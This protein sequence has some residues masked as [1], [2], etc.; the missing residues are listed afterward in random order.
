[1][2]RGILLSTAVFV[3]LSPI[4]C[5]GETRYVRAGDDLQAALNAARPGD[6]LRL[7]PDTTFS[8]N[9]VLP[10]TAGTS[11]ITVRTDLPDE[12]LPGPRQR[13]SPV[14]AARF[15]R[16]ASPN[17]AAALRTAPGANRW[18]LMFLTFPST[19]NG[20]GD[21]I[22][23]G[24]GSSAQSELSQVPYDIVLDRLYIHGDRTQGQ[25][26]GVALNARAVTIRN[27]HI[28]DI[29]AVGV[30]AQAIG[31][32]NGP[33]PFTIE[34][35]YLEA[36]G[37]VFLLGGSDPPIVNLVPADVSVRYN[38][39]TRPMAWRDAIV[40]PPVGVTA[41]GG[42]PGSLATGIYA[43]RVVA[44]SASGAGTVATS[45]P[46]SEVTAVASGGGVTVSWQ[47]VADASEYRVYVRTPAGATEY[48]TVTAPSFIHDGAPGR[49]GTPPTAATVWQVKNI[50]ELKAGRR[51]RVEYN[52]LENN[53]KNAQPGYAV[54]FTPRN[55]GGKCTW[56]VIEQVEFN[57]NVVRNVGGAFN[58][59]GYDV[60]AVTAQTNAIT[61][62]NNFV[63]DVTTELGGTGWPFLVGEAVRDVTIDHNTFDFD[64]S[65]LVYA[66][67]GTKT[68]PKP[69]T[70]FRFTNNAAPHGQYGINGANASTGTL[71]LQ[72]YFPAAQITGNWMSG[73][74]ESRYPA[75][76]RFEVPFDV[77]LPTGSGP[78]LASTGP[79]AN[80]RMLM[81]VMD[82]VQRGIM[83]DFP[84]APR[85][86][87]VI[88]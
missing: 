22:Q 35:N 20:Y 13:V 50:F 36:S 39:M 52:L 11:T 7:A 86:V 43:Y 30:D 62:H 29:K 53:W 67:G 19:K 72:M 45:L 77:N 74:S 46:S 9:F 59:A 26:R 51:V 38:H 69:M 61:I 34:N 85:S 21:I 37:E 25:K 6:E 78:A 71:T 42:A 58:I 16:I 31:G 1:M 32:W 73:G 24:D 49:S 48:W 76:N 15:A 10:V 56:C 88:F 57:H 18:R 55:Q 65:T 54:L 5:F 41:V 79:G 2:I 12:T 70:G 28:S 14:T 66:Y 3:L 87:R 84:V 23:L 82:S 81:L 33:G 63:Y 27:C 80:L 44:R 4:L 83:V 75:G 68:A 60:N 17:S 8:G 47:P 64:G 40:A